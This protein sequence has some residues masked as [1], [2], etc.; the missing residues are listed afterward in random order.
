ME[1]FVISASLVIGWRV[2]YAHANPNI[3]SNNAT[4]VASHAIRSRFRK[5]HAPTFSVTAG[6]G[7]CVPN[8]DSGRAP[9]EVDNASSAK[10]K[11]PADWNR[12]PGLFSK[13]RFTI[14]H[15]F[16]GPRGKT[17][18]RETVSLVNPAAITSLAVGPSKGLRP[19]NIS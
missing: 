11:S 5:N 9:D 1:D 13:Q 15:K 7:A 16:A 2:K 4:K 6:A 8:C 17:S 19:A 18:G 12:C 10:P 3:P 14:R